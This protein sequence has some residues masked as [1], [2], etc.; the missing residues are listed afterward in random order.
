V[1]VIGKGFHFRALGPSTIVGSAAF[2]LFCIIAVCI[3]SMTSPGIRM[4]KEIRVF[5][6]TAAFSIFAY[7]WLFIVSV[8]S[9]EVVDI[10]EGAV[11]LL[12]MP[13]LVSVS[14]CL[15]RWGLTWAL[16]RQPPSEELQEGV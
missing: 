14:Y 7:L 3:S 8:A 12:M 2:N 10:W 9:P 13:L 5:H 16:A 4:I 15:G 6:I 11:T 1:E